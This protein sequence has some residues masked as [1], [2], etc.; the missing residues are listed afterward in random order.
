MKGKF[1]RLGSPFFVR[2]VG[3]YHIG[4]LMGL[5]FIIFVLLMGFLITGFASGS[6]L[7]RDVCAIDA[8]SPVFIMSFSDLIV[9]S[10]GLVTVVLLLSWI[11]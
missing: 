6:F 2:F 3:F 7:V 9:C 10:F 11:D 4:M 8:F 5:H 1:F